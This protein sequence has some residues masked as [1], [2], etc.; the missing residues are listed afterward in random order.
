VAAVVALASVAAGAVVG[1][2]STLAG[3]DILTDSAICGRVS[4]SATNNAHVC[5]NMGVELQA[6]VTRFDE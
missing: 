4:A 3:V 1:F 6:Y 5:T 2:V